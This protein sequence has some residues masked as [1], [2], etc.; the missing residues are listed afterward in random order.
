MSYRHLRLF[1]L[2]ALFPLLA[3]CASAT[4]RFEQGME[5]EA[6][7]RYES[8]TMRYAQALE[9]DPHLTSARERLEYSGTMAVAQRLEEADFL[10]ARQQPVE[11]AGQFHRADAVEARVR[12]LGARVD[13]PSDYHDRRRD[14][15]DVAVL[16]LQE[17]GDHAREQ[18]RWQEGIVA[19][20]QARSEFEPDVVQRTQLLT[21]ESNLLVEWSH[22]EYQRGHL[23]AA[24]DAASRMQ[25]LEWSPPEDR[26]SAAQLMEQALAEGEVSLLVLP[27]HARARTRGSRSQEALADEV[28][29]MLQDSSWRQPPAFVAMHDPLAVRDLIEHTGVLDGP[30]DAAAL[31]AILRLTEADYGARFQLLG[32]QET[33][34]DVKTRTHHVD[35]HGGRQVTFDEHSGRR[36]LQ[37]EVRVLV[38]DNFGNAVTDVTVVGT[39]TAPFRVGDYAGDPSELNLKSQHVDLFD[40]YEQDRQVEEARRALAQDLAAGISAAVYDRV[41]AMVP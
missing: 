8:A 3:S 20:R 18:G 40:R 28:D 13:L 9:K 37:A 14:A 36:R 16:S 24:Y 2:L 1:T 35:T 26:A 31:A 22:R 27:V 15:F 7:G 32:V 6:Q 17:Q 10:A 25:E 12:S 5:L 21:A 4:K 34:F 23:R 39:G 33:E 30:F 38:V 29:A 41:L 19:Y 11:A